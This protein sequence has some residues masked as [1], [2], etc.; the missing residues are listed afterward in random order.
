MNDNF[1]LEYHLVHSC[2]LKCA[3]CSHY[4][5]LLDKL[6]F[7]SKEQIE[8]DMNLLKAC[9]NNGDALRWLRLLGEEP[10]LHLNLTACF[11]II[12]NVFPKTRITLITNGI[13]LNKMSVPFFK[14][15]IKIA[16]CCREFSLK[17]RFP[18]TRCKISE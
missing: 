16:S 6:T 4:S 10:L 8:S 13:N 11:N 1:G 14:V 12:R 2:N 5:S 15:S 18:T 9:T 3:G 7:V 17:M